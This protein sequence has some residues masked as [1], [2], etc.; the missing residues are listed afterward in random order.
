[1]SELAHKPIRVIMDDKKQHE[2]RYE[3]QVRCDNCGHFFC[4]QILKGVPRKDLKEIPCPKCQV[5]TRI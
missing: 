2:D 1:M 3:F 4:V 5:D